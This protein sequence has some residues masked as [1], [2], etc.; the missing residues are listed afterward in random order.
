[1]KTT[2]LIS[3]SLALLVP[4]AAFAEDDPA[5]HYD[6]GVKAEAARKFKEAV[7][8]YDK[9]IDIDEDYKDAFDRWDACQGLLTWEEELEGE[10]AALDLVRLGELYL[11]MNRHADEKKSY[12]DAL[13]LDKGCTE[14]HGHL[15]LWHYA[16]GQSREKF[17][18][19]YR[20]TLLFL[21]SS[22]YRA[23][24]A[25][26]IADFRI[27]GAMR[28]LRV[29]LGADARAASKLSRAKKFAEA[30]KLYRKEAAREGLDAGA[31]IYCLN[32]AGVALFKAGDAAGAREAFGRVIALPSCQATM[33][34]RL[35]L[36]MIETKAGNL[37][38]ALEHLKAAVA[39]GSS[40]CGT[41]AAQKGKAFKGLFKADD[42]GIRT[43]VEAL[44]D[45][46]KADDP[47]RAK[48][49]AARVQAGKEGKK[50]LLHWYGPY[51]PYVMAMQE[52]LVHPEVKKLIDAHYVY[53]RVDQGSMHKAVSLDREYGN[54]MNEHGVPCFIVLTPESSLPDVQ[55]DLALM[56]AEHRSYSVEKI[57]AWLAETAETE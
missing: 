20:E 7:E 37:M 47:L 41:I 19:V 45:E 55:K 29:L 43:A 34:A 26:A 42:G 54:V 4:I 30:A 17:P 32:Q 16:S 40:A 18:A 50:V 46:E 11:E 14:A 53:V 25:D 27:Y 21:E 3:L 10:P 51:C 1:M 36:G 12:E 28:N 23:A 57:V 48:I 24:L 56:G 15:A 31:R 49:A 52:R 13:A 38:A 6:A 2:L 44:T 5:P 33:Q 39:E 8:H 22:P 9:V 35:Y